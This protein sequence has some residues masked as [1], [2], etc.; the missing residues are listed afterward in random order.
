MK[1]SAKIWIRKLGDTCLCKFGDFADE[2]TK[3]ASSNEKL[4]AE[5]IPLKQTEAKLE[6][7][8]EKNGSNV[9]KLRDLVE[10]NRKYQEKQKKLIKDD[11]LQD[12]MEAVLDA[13]RSEDGH[14]SDR[15]IRMLLMRLKGLPAIEV[16]E[17]RFKAK[18]EKTRSIASVFETMRSIDN[19]KLPED[20]QIFTITKVAEEP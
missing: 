11:I 6:T 17:D 18:L 15:E 9:N 19:N 20:E 16:N 13:E 1:S 7:I 14:F 3:L 10:E 4:E 12:M 5:L 2:N 8:A